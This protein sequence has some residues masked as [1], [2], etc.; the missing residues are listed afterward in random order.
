MMREWSD[1]ERS[2]V[3]E[4]LL[5]LCD[6]EID[7]ESVDIS[8]ADHLERITLAARPRWSPQNRPMVDGSKPANGSAAWD[9]K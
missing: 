2:Q 1:P 4:K 3:D 8:N 7:G 5:I 9:D 6:E